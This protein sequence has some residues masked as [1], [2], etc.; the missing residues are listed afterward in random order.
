M[1]EFGAL[2][3][4][5][6]RRIATVAALAVVLTVAG[7]ID[8]PAAAAVP[9]VT[10]ATTLNALWNGYGDAGGHWTGGDS[11]ASVAL[12]DG[13]V[14]WLFSDTF[15]GTVNA[16]GTRPRSAPM[17]NNS[18]VV[19][20]QG[21]LVSTR[22]GGTAAAPT[23]LVSEAGS[24]A[25][26][27]VGDGLVDGSTLK[28]LYGKYN[29]TGDGPLDIARA[30]T[31]LATFNLPALTV[32]SV[33]PLPLGS[34]VAWGSAVLNDGGFTYIY[35]SERVASGLTFAHVAR[36]PVGGLGGAWTFWD[37]SGWSA[38][39]TSSARL[40][41]GVGT[42]FG[43]SRV[44]TEIVLV[45]QDS[46]TIF[47]PI[48]V[49]YRA[50]APAGPFTGPT[51]LLQA[52][53]PGIGQPL[54]IYDTRFHPEHSAAGHLMVSYN[55]NSLDPDG[56][57]N[58]ASIYRPR[59][60]DVTWPPPQSDPAQLPAAPTA[61]S[62][63]SNGDGAVQLAW[64]A[65]NGTGLTYHVFQRDAT[66][67]QSNF[68]RLPR[69]YTS[70]GALV[71]VPR[72]G[73]VYEFKVTAVNSVG[74]GPPSA[75]KS[76]LVDVSP[77]AAPTGL[78]TSAD[79]LGQLTLTWTATP[80]ATNYTIEQRD[81]TAGETESRPL[82]YPDST[83]TTVRLR[84]LQSGDTYSFTVTARNAGGESPPS[85]AVAAT[86]SLA[87]P[88]A[89]TALA[90]AA[91]ADGTITLNWTSTGDHWY[92]IYQRDVTAG[93]LDFTQLAY[94]IADGTTF[95]AGLLVNDHTYQFKVVA[96]GDGGNSA[97]TP[98]ASATAHYPPPPSPAGLTA[99]PQ[100]DGTI[101]LDWQSPAEGLWFWIYQRDITAGATSYTQLPYPV[102]AGTT[103]TAGL[104]TQ[105]HVYD[106]QVT[107]IGQ[108]GESVPTAPARATAHGALPPTPTGLTATAGDGQVVLRW[109][110]TRT[111]LWYSVYVR[112][113]T[114]GE[115]GFTQLPLPVTSGTTMT[116]GYLTNGHTYA[117]EVSALNSA[118]EGPPSGP[119]QAVPAA[120]L[121]ATP[122]ALSAKANTDGSIKL[123]WTAPANLWYWIYVRDVTAGD[124]DFTKLNYPITMGQTFTAGLLANNHVYAF[125]VSAINSTGE[126]PATSAVQA[127]AHYAAPTTPRNL[128][129]HS[130][131][132]GS[133]VLD[134]DPP[135]SSADVY[136]WVHMRDA[137]AGEAFHKLAYPTDHTDFTA[138]LLV[139]GHSYQFKVAATNT[140]GDGPTT[141]AVSITSTGGLPKPPGTLTASAGDTT[142]T[143]TWSA[144]ASPNVLYV[145]Y[146]RD[147]TTG[148][149]WQVLPLPT[150]RLIATVGLLANGHSY[151]FKVTASNSAGQSAPTNTATA[152]P[153]PSLPKAPTGLTATPQIGA[154]ALKWSASST[155]G[156]AYWIETRDD[157]TGQAWQRLRYPVMS[158]TTFTAGLLVAH[159]YQFRVGA[160]NMT[161]DSAASATVTARPL[162]PSPASGLTAT[163]GD[164]KVTLK[165]TASS[166][167]GAL[168]WI[169][170]RDKTAS[171]SFHRL[172]YPVA[173]TSF[174]AAGLKRH[175]YEFRIV[176][177]AAYGDSAATATASAVPL[178]PEGP[179]GLTATPGDQR[180]T[181]KWK[182][183]VTA[184]V[185]YLIEIRDATTGEAWHRLPL[186]IT[187]TSFTA[188]LLVN[189][190]SYQF[191][192]L[193]TGSSG[194]SA[195]TISAAAKP[196]PPIPKAAGLVIARADDNWAGAVKVSWGA[197]GTPRVWYRL[198]YRI[199]N[200]SDN[201]ERVLPTFGT[202]KFVTGLP[203]GAVVDFHVAAV[204]ESGAKDSG[205]RD[206]AVPLPWNGVFTE[207]GNNT[208]NG[209]DLSA[210]LFIH[211]H[212]CQYSNRQIV[213]FNGSPFN[214][215]PKT[216]GNYLFYKW[217]KADLDTRLTNE[218]RCR[219][220]MI[221]Y[222]GYGS[223]TAEKYGPDL[224]RHE[225][226][227]T[228]Q[229]NQYH[230]WDLP[231]RLYSQFVADYAEQSLLSE[232]RYGNPWQ[233]NGFEIQA[234]LYWGGYQTYNPSL[235][236]C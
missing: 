155:P 116:A 128:R 43:V 154:I 235:S 63:T 11:T 123:T 188:G 53:E 35:G 108:G 148:E 124:V 226:V 29:K 227:H 210:T 72:G 182:A 6:R 42:G 233:G 209:A 153:M 39:E 213:C 125:K 193:S 7:V 97:M 51:E 26:Y 92:W 54:I 67:G 25:L 33:Q 130:S 109:T 27:W 129:G 37:G 49:A 44:G 48:A 93:D 172:R 3:A 140:G 220:S 99:A 30:G 84:Y 134:W 9:P 122:S 202:S 145:I 87:A 219:L 187:T 126:G 83:A 47:S 101:E 89:P 173:A 164:G 190:H 4:P 107:S 34:S 20:D 41:S 106:F 24:S 222:Y 236:Y 79:S 214:S 103:F 224:L 95:T 205:Y 158:G 212:P 112:D 111:D 159:S 179:T 167:P 77:P 17:V 216:I 71:S 135:T 88:P 119:V 141:A 150:S 207:L 221:K 143:L 114:A 14:A 177:A 180:V 52:P 195:A 57:Y 175:T 149:S 60:V 198:Y 147:V 110:A 75:T 91:N 160:T 78:A 133:I 28:V 127:T 211:S 90:A 10:S 138:T 38:T 68:S 59:F 231:P 223:S 199:R 166:T 137:T 86:V 196:M 82:S 36:V 105:D 203:E 120:P 132:D 136:Y 151:Q 152:S 98:A 58:D 232:A 208:R 18:L 118:G 117:F 142:V 31:V 70:P 162:P 191:R 178:V 8:R 16:D 2:T 157:T 104:L 55:L 230:F 215:Q 56:N 66:A 102:A 169:E 115:S 234:N 85:S 181:L 131:G 1:A 176:A 45:T 163:A 23:S 204:N 61:I 201:V 192:V 206:D 194:E 5:A 218:A 94:P 32:A 146:Q 46:N 96:I 183:S 168:Y 174:A 73:D 200:Y 165:W 12:P 100:P 40:F 76:L 184:G 62:A 225:A 121:P 144:S 185:W 80:R 197:S 113:I 74:E 228:L 15:L 217:S 170:M 64:T 50:P 161:G 186:P 19:E 65:P 13:R 69:A 81:L 139:N 22:T 171:E 189:A 21:Q 156:V 229:A